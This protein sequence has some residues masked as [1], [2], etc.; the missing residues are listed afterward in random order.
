P[1]YLELVL[2]ALEEQMYSSAFVVS[3]LK[4]KVEIGFVNV[5]LCLPLI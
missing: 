4:V 1:Y 3:S 5:A 2:I